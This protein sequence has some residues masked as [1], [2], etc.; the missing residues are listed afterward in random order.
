MMFRRMCVDCG[1]LV[2]CSRNEGDELTCA[3]C[4]GVLVGPVALPTPASYRERCAVLVSPHYAG[5]VA[6][7]GRK[8]A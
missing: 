6:K 5:A 1:D 7:P 2:V 8:R 4:G 3:R